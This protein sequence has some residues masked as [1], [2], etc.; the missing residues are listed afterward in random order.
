MR[1]PQG[2]A[3][4]PSVHRSLQSVLFRANSVNKTDIVALSAG[5]FGVPPLGGG[6]LGVSAFTRSGWDTPP[7][8]RLKAGFRA[9]LQGFSDAKKC[10]KKTKKV[11]DTPLRLG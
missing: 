5:W 9:T 8:S 6:R 3:R 1:R 2:K 4:Q 7:P 10:S 11:V